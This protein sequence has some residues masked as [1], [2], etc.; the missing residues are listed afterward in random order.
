MRVMERIFHIFESQTADGNIPIGL[1]E[2]G[3]PKAMAFVDGSLYPPHDEQEAMI[4][5]IAVTKAFGK[6]FP[7]PENQKERPWVD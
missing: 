7:V 6:P 4:F 5:S 1:V 2:N 3:V